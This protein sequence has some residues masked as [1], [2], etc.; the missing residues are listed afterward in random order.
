MVIE[1]KEENEEE[2]KKEKRERV[3]KFHWNKEKDYYFLF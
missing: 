1:E 3:R 2:K